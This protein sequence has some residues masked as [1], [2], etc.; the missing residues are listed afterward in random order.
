MRNVKTMSG[1]EGEATLKLVADHL[2]KATEA[3]C[4]EIGCTS[5]SFALTS[6]AVLVREL[7]SIEPEATSLYLAALS[8]LTDFD[9]ID[10]ARAEAQQLRSNSAIRIMRAADLYFADAEGRG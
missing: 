2:S 6:I 10:E 7:H 9:V 5:V 3:G 8:R 4:K 1:E